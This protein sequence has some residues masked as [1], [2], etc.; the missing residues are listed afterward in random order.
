MTPQAFIEETRGSGTRRETLAVTEIYKS[1]QGES[2][3]AGLP[4]IFVRLTGCHLRCVWCDTTYAFQGGV[5]TDLQDILTRCREL[6]GNLV[7]ITGGEPLLQKNC[8]ALARR[9]HAEGY[10][11]LCETSGTLPISMLPE[12]TIKIMD[13]KCP[14]SGEHGRNDWSNIN[15]L[16]ARDEVKFVLADR[17][18]YEW[19][20]DVTREYGL[21][22]RTRAVLFS[23]V[24]DRL[25]PK[26]LAEW[27][28]EDGLEVRLHIPLHKV[29]WSPDTKGV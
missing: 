1:I 16:S 21:A 2:T 14:G 18:D 3:W 10:T 9:L 4:C 27:I 7:E 8:G 17:A 15:R 11:V 19:S 28:L 13:L 23:P 22:S 12:E 25:E 24:W 6:G 29:V 5:Q 20:R 26:Q